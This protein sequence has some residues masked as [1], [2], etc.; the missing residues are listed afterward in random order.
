MRLCILV[1]VA[2]SMKLQPCVEP[3]Y[4]LPLSFQHLCVVHTCEFTC[5]MR[6]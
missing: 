3:F 1:K 2:D 4:L 5:R 6:A